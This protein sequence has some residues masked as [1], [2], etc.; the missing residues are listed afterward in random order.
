MTSGS[1]RRSQL[2][3]PFGVGA[4]TVLVDGT[5][6]ISAGLD[7]WF[8]PAREDD[9][10][11][12]AEFRIEEW[13]LRNRLKVDYFQAPPPYITSHEDPDKRH[14]LRLSI[15]FL[16]FP[17]WN[18]CAYCRR[19]VKRPYHFRGRLHCEDESH[20]EGARSRRRRGKGPVMA[21]VPFVVI[22]EEGHLGDF[23]WEEWVHG[24]AEPG[25]NA[26]LRLKSS[27]GGSLANQKVHCD[28]CSAERS[29]TGVTTAVSVGTEDGSTTVLS[30]D[31]DKSK[32]EYTCRGWRPWLGE[33]EEACGRPVRG[34]LRGSSNVYFP[35]VE[36][37]I[38][39][40]QGSSTVPEALLRLLTGAQF[41]PALTLLK[42]SP[43]APRVD[44]LLRMDTSDALSCYRTEQ[45]EAA[46]N[47]ILGGKHQRPGEQGDQAEYSL[48]T[49]SPADWRRPEYARLR[50]EMDN[51]NLVVAKPREEDYGDVVRDAFSRVRL[52]E[53]LRETRALWGFTRVTS[54]NVT[55]EVGKSRLRRYP[56]RTGHDWL[57]AYTV[58]GEGIYLELDGNR[59]RE[60]EGRADVRARTANLSSRF[61]EALGNPD[62]VT[63]RVVLVH[64]IAHLLINQLIFDCGYSTA[65]L[66]ERLFVSD[67]EER[68]MAGM[69]IYTA[70][71]DADGTMG[72][73]VRMGKPGNLEHVWA[74][75]LDNAE[76]C[77]TDPICMEL[78]ETGQGPGSCNL[79]A[80]H[81]C[82]L[83]PETSCEK[84]NQ[85]LD[86]GLVVGSLKEPGMGY[87]S[88]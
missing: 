77:S 72:G 75:A 42:T 82:A 69:L 85:L 15:P 24:S 51:P 57:P 12:P 37:S 59:L 49:I 67:G 44:T 78:G 8:R 79:A 48:D 25:C 61:H 3:S 22:C 55:L 43:H 50:D 40:P 58:K 54:Q 31:L 33:A 16:R 30:R 27:G 26:V 47:E 13:R 74:S 65:S 70:A 21:Q 38:Y 64:T 87:F 83:L 20:S 39:L 5:S 7:Y 68:P 14:N 32:A 6:V 80:C 52:V 23:P 9:E 29:L 17:G 76:W 63:P 88:I 73:L 10:V 36:S 4:M 34:S 86:R 62:D 28:T 1:I 41:S 81:S 11:N 71:G 84:F 35:L 60:W 19:L 18:F 45:I 56:A 2:I 66:R 53:V 46:L